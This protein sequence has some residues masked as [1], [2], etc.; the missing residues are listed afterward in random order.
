MRGRRPVV[1]I[2]AAR[3]FAEQQGYRWVPNPDAD[4]PYDALAYQ[5]HDAIAV[6]VRTSRNSPGEY[7]L[8]EEFFRDDF[9]ILRTLPMSEGISREL[10]VRYVWSRIFQRYRVY[11]NRLSEITMIDR[12]KPAFPGYTTPFRGKPPDY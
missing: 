11:D 1:T 7:D 9:D 2:E 8:W 6:R 4:M 12:K 10:W 5:D 3:K